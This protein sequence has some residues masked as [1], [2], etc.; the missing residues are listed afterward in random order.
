MINF[1]RNNH[2]LRK[3]RYA[4]L[5]FEFKEIQH[6]VNWRGRYMSSRELM[7][8]YGIKRSTL[9][10]VSQWENE[11]PICFEEAKEIFAKELGLS[12]HERK[13]AEAL[14]KEWKAEWEE[15]NKNEEPFW[16][17]DPDEAGWIEE[18]QYIE[19]EKRMT[20]PAR[21]AFVEALK[22]ANCGS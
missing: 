3:E 17:V 11:D 19:Y 21:N 14:Y 18:Q 8:E 13:E 12:D 16:V 10:L 1:F 22:K 7:K 6:W 4:T 2:Q 5:L 20:S 9:L 15:W